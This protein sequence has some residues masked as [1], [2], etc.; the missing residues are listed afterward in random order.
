MYFINFI[1]FFFFHLMIQFFFFLKK[2]KKKADAIVDNKGISD[3]IFGDDDNDNDN[4]DAEK[5]KKV[6]IEEIKPKTKEDFVKYAET[7][8]EELSRYD[9]GIFISYKMI[10]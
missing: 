10:L 3:D 5:E 8:Y 4:N 2:K 1:I 9:V 6:F 7:V